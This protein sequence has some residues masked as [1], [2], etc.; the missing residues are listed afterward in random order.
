MGSGLS[1]AYRPEVTPHPMK[2]PT[3]DPLLG[4]PEGRK[5]RGLSI[6]V[7]F[8]LFFPNFVYN[9]SSDDCHRRRDDFSKNSPQ[10]S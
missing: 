8:I 2:E 10:K 7:T 9:F 5:E 1:L 4:F 3:N 6:F